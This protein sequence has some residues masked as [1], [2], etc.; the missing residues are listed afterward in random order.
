MGLGS[1]GLVG[2]R[3]LSNN[4]NRDCYISIY[5]YIYIY[6]HIYMVCNPWSGRA[7]SLW[8]AFALRNEKR[9]R[10]KLS[11]ALLFHSVLPSCAHHWTWLVELAM[12]AGR[13]LTWLP[14]LR[15]HLVHWSV[16]TVSVCS[17]SM[18]P[19]SQGVLSQLVAQLSCRFCIMRPLLL[20]HLSWRFCIMQLLLLA[21]F[22]VYCFLLA[23]VQLKAPIS[24]AMKHMHT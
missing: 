24:W 5:I 4:I 7:G 15:C 17:L 22:I 11:C 20:A 12:L 23:M 16:A 13:H 21:S 3:P 18:W 6:I 1:K 19:A 9:K 8:G 10:S 14:S 2:S